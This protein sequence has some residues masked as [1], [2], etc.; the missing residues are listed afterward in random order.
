MTWR[1]C[2]TAH[3]ALGS[4][5]KLNKWKVAFMLLLGIVIITLGALFVLVT[6]PVE[7]AEIPEPMELD[8]NTILLETTVKEF[9]AI[10]KQYLQDQLDQSPVPIEIIMD[11]SIV[12]NSTLTV[13]GVDVP[14]A[15]DFEPVVEDGNIRLK[16]TEMNIGKL[17]IPPKSVLKIMKDS[18]KLPDIITIL[19]NDEEIY[20]DLSRVNIANGARVKA[21]EIDMPN[22]RI[23][24]EMVVQGDFE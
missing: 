14:I 23:I 12:L 2:P 6:S 16:Q 13:F 20:V 21:K 9:E 15:M 10:S 3:W 5:R 22:D 7:Q 4:D 17:H 11:D 24:L 8:G 1:Q 18:V 19:P